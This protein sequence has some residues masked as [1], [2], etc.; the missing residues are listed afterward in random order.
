MSDVSLKFR[1]TL[2]NEFTLER[3]EIFKKQLSKDG[4][5]KLLL[6]MKDESLVETVLMRYNYGN[7]A[8]VSSEV[9]CNMGCAFCASGFLKKKRNLETSEMVGQILVLDELLKE[10]GN[11]ERVTHIVVMGTGEPFDNYDNNNFNI[12]SCICPDVF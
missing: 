9:G 10:E 12:W 8:C 6:K 2:N 7:V 3:P 1:E 5:I 4:T 11:N